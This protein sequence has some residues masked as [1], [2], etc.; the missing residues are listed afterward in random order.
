MKDVQGL[1]QAVAERAFRRFERE[2]TKKGDGILISTVI[3]QWGGQSEYDA[4]GISHVPRGAVVYPDGAM[5]S[6]E[7]SK[8]D[9]YEPPQGKYAK[10]CRICEYWQV[11]QHR[12]RQHYQ[13]QWRELEQQAKHALER[14]GTS[15]Q[16]GEPSDEE[17]EDLAKLKAH[18][19]GLERKV[20]NAYGVMN[21]YRPKAEADQRE[22]VRK[23]SVRY[24]ERALQRLDKLKPRGVQEPEQSIEEADTVRQLMSR[25]IVDTGLASPM[26]QYDPAYDNPRRVKL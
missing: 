7:G 25:T 12:C 5:R 19:D 2:H 18:L 24:A 15:T 11:V 10:W 8:S 20:R 9:L 26:S 16:G 17:I 14:A 3:P 22:V 4:L 1:G 21:K 13:Q 23:E 6:D